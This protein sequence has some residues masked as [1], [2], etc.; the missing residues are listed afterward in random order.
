MHKKQ[1]GDSTEDPLVVADV[2]TPSAATAAAAFSTAPLLL[3]L[4]SAAAAYAGQKKRLP[5]PCSLV[6]LSGGSGASTQDRVTVEACG[7]GGSGGREGAP[8]TAEPA[9]GA[10]AVGSGSGHREQ[11]EEGSFPPFQR[12]SR[13]TK[14]Y[15]DDDDE[16]EDEGERKRL[17]AG[18]EEPRQQGKK[19][20]KERQR[21][22]EEEEA[23]PPLLPSPPPPAAAAAAAAAPCR[24][25]L[26]LAAATIAV[27]LRSP[28]GSAATGGE[29]NERGAAAAAGTPSRPAP[30]GNYSRYYGYR[31][32]L[33]SSPSSSSGPAAPA[34]PLL[35]AA[36]EALYGPGAA[37]PRL[38]ALL[39]YLPL[40]RGRRLLDV[41]CNGGVLTL[42]LASAAGAAGAV[43]VDADA[44]LVRS[45]RARCLRQR[46]SAAAGQDFPTALVVGRGVNDDPVPVEDDRAEHQSPA[47]VTAPVEA[48]VALAANLASTPRR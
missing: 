13:H 36:H 10:A 29:G 22:D 34:P 5:A 7:L 31:L 3:P 48:L 44:R 35:S 30:R 41:G 27:A 1:Q 37:D 19:K 8:A 21:P 42:A 15:D 9:R 20:R 24:V 39:P 32:G 6:L 12:Q 18:D 23:A 16:D 38:R 4:S 11:E 26:S 45:A 33:S 46:E 43:G 40:L 28:Q 17:K 47:S 14:F 25:D 2:R